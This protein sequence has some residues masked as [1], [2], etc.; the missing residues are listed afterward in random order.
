[1]KEPLPILIIIALIIVA[2]AA[3]LIVTWELEPWWR[4]FP[5]P[6]RKIDDAKDRVKLFK[7]EHRHPEVFG[8]ETR[9]RRLMKLVRLN[10]KE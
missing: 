4:K 8:L 9:L 1:V 5:T 3:V 10:K 7:I 2:I 6:R